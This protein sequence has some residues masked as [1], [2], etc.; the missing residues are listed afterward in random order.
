MIVYAIKD[1]D[2]GLFW[3]RDHKDFRPLAQN[4][5]FLVNEGQVKR[6]TEYATMGYVRRC[7]FENKNIIAVKIEIIEYKDN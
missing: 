7:A 3:N 4:T 1:L 5:L 2:T 6:A